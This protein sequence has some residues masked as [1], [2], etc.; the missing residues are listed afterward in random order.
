MRFVCAGR[1]PELKH[2]PRTEEESACRWEPVSGGGGEGREWGYCNGGRGAGGSAVPYKPAVAHGV[3]PGR[4][5]TMPSRWDSGESSFAMG[6]GVRF[7]S[8]PA[9]GMPSLR[10][11]GRRRLRARGPWSVYWFSRRAGTARARM[12]G[13]CVFIG[14]GPR[15]ANP[16]VFVVL[17]LAART[18]KCFWFRASLREPGTVRS[19][20]GY[21]LKTPPASRHNRGLAPSG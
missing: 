1:E 6:P 8:P 15:C 19:T 11:S 14:S 17:G 3:F 13:P 5:R 20:T 4:K 18:R 21:F 2:E 16:K 9:R 12:C 10:D 7:A